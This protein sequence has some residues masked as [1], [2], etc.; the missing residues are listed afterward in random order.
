M[1]VGYELRRQS[2]KGLYYRGK[3][4][5]RAELILLVSGLDQRERK[6][7]KER[8]P[9]LDF[10]RISLVR[11]SP[12]AGR[13]IRG[14]RPKGGRRVVSTSLGEERWRSCAQGFSKVLEGRRDLR[15]SE[16]EIRVASRGCADSIAREEG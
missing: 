4:S 11:E 14:R 13:T 1:Q 16:C 9:P 10:S 5:R 8:G 7:P 15:D 2:R 6:S 3:N 12:P